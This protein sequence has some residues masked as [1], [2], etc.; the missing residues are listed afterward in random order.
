MFKESIEYLGI[1]IVNG[2]IQMHQPIVVDIANFLDELEDPKQIQKFLGIVKYVHKYIP[3]LSQ[4][5]API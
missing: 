3:R 5:I 2:R 1:H 4:L